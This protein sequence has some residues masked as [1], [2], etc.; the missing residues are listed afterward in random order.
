MVPFQTSVDG[1]EV[2]VGFKNQVFAVSAEYGR[3]GIVPFLRNGIFLF[4]GQVVDIGYR[5]VVGSRLGVGYP[6]AVR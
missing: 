1:V 2:T 4:C 5:K 3:R 6:A